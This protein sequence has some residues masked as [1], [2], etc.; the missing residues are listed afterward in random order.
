M[1]REFE[2]QKALD[3]AREALD[4]A[5]AAYRRALSAMRVYRRGQNQQRIARDGG[6]VPRDTVRRM[7]VEKLMGSD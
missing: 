5:T 2:L 6:L 4:L 3:D 7:A 1:S